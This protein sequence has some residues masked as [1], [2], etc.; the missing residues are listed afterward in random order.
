MAYAAQPGAVQNNDGG[1]TI[2]MSGPAYE[3]LSQYADRMTQAGVSVEDM[4][5]IG[6]NIFTE[7]GTLN[8]AHLA[9]AARAVEADRAYAAQT[10]HQYK[11]NEAIDTVVEEAQESLKPRLGR[12]AVAAGLLAAFGLSGVAAADMS[13]FRPSYDSP[14]QTW[15]MGAYDNNFLYGLRV[16]GDS[17]EN[18]FGTGTLDLQN[19]QGETRDQFDFGFIDAALQ[20]PGGFSSSYDPLN[21]M[22]S[23]MGDIDPG[24]SYSINF[25]FDPNPDALTSIVFGRTDGVY[26]GFATS[27][28]LSDIDTLE[29]QV[30]P[31]PSAALLALLGFGTLGLGRKKFREAMK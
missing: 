10:G 31:L 3:A 15:S 5:R 21:N 17:F 25:T 18:L 28:T 7:T 13:Y 14:T 27:G 2:S 16:Q 19:I 24:D 6:R 23:I 1:V 8:L 11:P 26:T 12:K 29:T 30:V 20:L 22:M 9:S 4:G